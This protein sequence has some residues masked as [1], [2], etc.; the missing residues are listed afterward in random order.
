MMLY[1]FL[2]LLHSVASV[3]ILFI[4]NSLTARNDLPDMVRHLIPTSIVVRAHTVPG[5]TLNVHASNPTTRSLIRNGTWT[6]VVLQ[7]QSEKLSYGDRGYES[8]HV[9]PSARALASDVA[10]INATLVWYQTPAHMGGNGVGD[11]YEAMQAR[12]N[13]GYEALNAGVGYVPS[14]VAPVGRAFR[15]LAN[16]STLFTDSVHPSKAGTYL[17]ALVFYR[18]ITGKVAQKTKWRPRGISKSFAVQARRWTDSVF[19][20]IQTT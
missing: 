3:R 11:S 10:F 12:I 9:W 19:P 18:T 2:L 16:R 17:A 8:T 7:E 6:H 4:G 13:A 5:A 15:M 1:I 14:T 20:P